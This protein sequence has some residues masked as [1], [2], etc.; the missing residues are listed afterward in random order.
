M[1]SITIHKLDDDLVQCIEERARK[2]NTSMNRII[3]QLLRSALGLEKLPE[4]DNREQFLDLFGT[5]SPK[6][7]EYFDLRVN[8]LEQIDM[9]EWQA[10]I[11]T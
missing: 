6:E 4:V 9:E 2:E 1:K 10:D 8:D 3:K 7:A 5:W 11:E